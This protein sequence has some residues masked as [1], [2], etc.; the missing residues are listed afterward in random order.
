MPEL[1]IRHTMRCDATQYWRCVFDE[2]YNRRLYLD[3]L[4]FREFAL[5]EQ[6]DAGA[7]IRRRVRLNPPATDLPGP[8]AKVVGDVSWIEE[9]T[10]TRATDRYAFRTIT[11]SLPD[12]TRIAGELWC[13]PRG[14]G[15]VERIARI[16][17]EVKVMIVGSIIEKV[18]ADD[19]RRSYDEAARFTESFVVEKGW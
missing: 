7:S 14:E 5:L 2:E 8:V 12:K 3:R 17:V 13:E 15:R 11:A 10:W 16:D 9:G 6:T 19:I 1:V 18:I 4:H